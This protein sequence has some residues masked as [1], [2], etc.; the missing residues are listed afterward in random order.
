MRQAPHGGIR[1]CVSGAYGTLFDFASVARRTE[2]R[3]RRQTG[4]HG[5]PRRVLS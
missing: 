1:V 4:G 3:L 2:S 5:R